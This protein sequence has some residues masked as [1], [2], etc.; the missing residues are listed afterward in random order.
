[1]FIRVL[2]V[3]R[4]EKV[5]VVRSTRV[6]LPEGERAAALHIGNGVIERI[7]EY[8]RG[9]DRREGVQRARPGRPAPM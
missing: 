9:P 8:A 3:L 7:V 4:V 1:V 5:L 6:V 2:C